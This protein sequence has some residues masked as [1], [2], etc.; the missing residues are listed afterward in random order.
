MGPP[1]EK[2]YTCCKTK[3]SQQCVCI[4]CG[5]IVH[6]SC[7]KRHDK[8]VIIDATRA[9]CCLSTAENDSLIVN[10]MKE[11]MNKLL[12]EKAKRIALL[13]DKISCLE[14]S[15]SIVNLNVAKSY[16]EILTTEKKVPP[17]LVKP[18]ERTSRGKIL[19]KIQNEVKLHELNISV[20]TL[21]ETRDGSL[22]IKCNNVKNNETMKS[23]LQKIPNFN[24]EIKTL[25]M[26]RPRVK[27][28]DVA[29]DIEEEEIKSF[30]ISQNFQ[31]STNDDYDI[32]HVQ[33]NKKKGTKTIFMELAPELFRS[34]MKNRT[35]YIGW[36]RCRVFED[37]N[38][39]RCFKCNGYA[40]SAKKCQS[41]VKCQYCAKNH[42][43]ASCPDK[44]VK[45]CVN[46][47]R[48]NEKYNK[49]HD[50]AH[51]AFDENS[52]A[53]YQFYKQRVINQTNYR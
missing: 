13:E 35:L 3:Q 19:K 25:E 16:A 27:V 38:L 44:K 36:Q 33:N 48:T 39:S 4:N 30:V 20:D 53:T 12:T 6:K 37:F 29:G 34:V 5:A 10:S 40:H 24:C 43:G 31:N 22:L 23:E 8:F 41:E 18:N 26:K 49:E 7:L 21:K 17:I 14:K 46:C 1:E 51:F 52:C 50:V 2:R 15:S 42:D 9:I 47:M 28:V 32:V 11:L 45:C